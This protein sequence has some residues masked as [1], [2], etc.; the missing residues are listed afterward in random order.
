MFKRT[1]LGMANEFLFHAVQFTVYC[2]GRP[3]TGPECSGDEVFWTNLFRRLGFSV[4]VKSV[5]S[6]TNALEV[7]YEVRD[8]NLKNVLVCVD[9]DYDD[10]IGSRV[11]HPALIYTRG[12]SWESDCIS[13]IDFF[14]AVNLFINT[15]NV[16][17]YVEEFN[18]FAHNFSRMLRKVCDLDIKYYCAPEALFD[19][20]KPQS[21]LC[22]DY[23]QPPRLN[24]RRLLNSA[25]K[26][27]YK[28]PFT[29][30]PV[31]NP[32]LAFFGKST[33]K[34][35]YH[36]LVF[37]LIKEKNSRKVPF[38]VFLSHIAT[39]NDINDNETRRYYTDA[40]AR[41]TAY[42]APV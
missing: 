41:F 12:Y 38:E 19:R 25:S 9:S 5:G 34:I 26:I 40:V 37:R 10:Y 39:S 42:T 22:N 23:S 11:S 15:A 3:S 30:K 18:V 2:E 36:W 20:S 21:I 17:T 13:C 35:V 4:K 7:F 14:G 24:I 32:W 16:E 28:P 33:A 27:R 6:K 29:W 8:K 31:D 1:P